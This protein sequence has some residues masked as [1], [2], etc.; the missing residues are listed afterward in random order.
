[1]RYLGGKH[2]IA[3]WLLE[4]IQPIRGKR[5]LIEPFCGGLSATVTLQPEI[6]SDASIPLMSLILACRQGWEPPTVLS[7]LE[8]Q[9]A[10]KLPASDPLHGFAA[11]CCSFGGKYWGGYARETGR[12]FALQ[13]RNSLMRK[14]ESTRSTNFICCPY[15]GLEVQ[16]GDVWYC[17]PPYAGTTMGYATEPWESDKFWEWC[18]ATANKGTTVIVSEFKAPYDVPLLAQLESKTDLRTR[19]RDQNTVESLFI[20]EGSK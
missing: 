5:R 15:H 6:A 9:H 20:L 3:K 8:Y 18:R 4:Q 13:G 11:F 17:D 16:T 1:M 10:R 7:E 2:R 19:H 12:N 14:I